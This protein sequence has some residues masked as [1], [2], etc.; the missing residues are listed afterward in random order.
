MRLVFAS[1]V[2][3][4]ACGGGASRGTGAESP[5]DPPAGSATSGDTSNAADTASG[6]GSENDAE[7]AGV[8]GKTETFPDATS[9]GALKARLGKGSLDGVARLDLAGRSLGPGL[10]KLLGGAVA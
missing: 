5:A 7:L 10:G 9:L 2:M 8:Q 3:L 1:L 6:V 4:V